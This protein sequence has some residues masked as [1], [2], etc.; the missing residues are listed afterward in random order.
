MSTMCPVASDRS[1]S[2]WSGPRCD[3]SGAGVVGLPALAG[4]AAWHARV[5]PAAQVAGPL[6]IGT[7][8]CLSL[9]SAQRRFTLSWPMYVCQAG[10]RLAHRRLLPGSTLAQLPVILTA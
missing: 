3:V 10:I 8:H 5:G 6:F 9:C 1:K 4:W 7:K 2:G